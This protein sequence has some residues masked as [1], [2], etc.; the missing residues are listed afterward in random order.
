MNQPFYEFTILDEALRYDFLSEGKNTIRKAIVYYATDM[1]DTYH[2]L[3][4]DILESGKVDVYA[5]SDNGDMEKVLAT[6]VQSLF[7]FFGKHPQSFVIFSGSTLVRTRL[8]QI[9]LARELSAVSERFEIKGFDGI[10][11]EPFQRNK[12][13]EG[14]GVSLKIN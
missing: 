8:Y 3:M 1:P 4:G 13:Y 9:A 6:V 10:Y 11:F 7:V 5:I 12:S 2:L 14:F